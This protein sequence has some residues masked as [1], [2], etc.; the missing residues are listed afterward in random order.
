MAYCAV[1]GAYRSIKKLYFR[2]FATTLPYIAQKAYVQGVS[3]AVA[4]TKSV[5]A[6]GILVQN[7]AKKSL[8]LVKNQRFW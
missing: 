4:A 2:E 3:S 1:S 5:A 7:A 6:T 8:F